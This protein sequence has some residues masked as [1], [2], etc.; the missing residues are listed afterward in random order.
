MKSNSLGTPTGW[1]IAPVILGLAACSPSKSDEQAVGDTELGQI[2]EEGH[3]SFVYD[4]GPNVGE[5]VPININISGRNGS[6]DLA[7]LLASGPAVLIFTRSVE[8]CPHCQAELVQVNTELSAIKAK[9]YQ[10]FAI[11]YDNIEMVNKFAED[12]KLDFELFSD[13][14]STFIDA[15]DLR[16]PQFTSGRAEG[17][18]IATVIVVDKM[19]AVMAKTISGNHDDDPPKDQIITLLDSL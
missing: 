19:G 8:W 18:A 1:L 13:E 12:Q 2:A 14:D 16:D 3:V 7:A 11:S 5:R 4:A 6:T 17:A 15:I 9:G 10:V